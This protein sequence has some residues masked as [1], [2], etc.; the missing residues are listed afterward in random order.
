MISISEFSKTYGD[1]VSQLFKRWVNKYLE[2]QTDGSI[3]NMWLSDPTKKYPLEKWG[4]GSPSP[5]KEKNIPLLQI[6]TMVLP[7]EKI[8]FKTIEEAEVYIEKGIN[9]YEEETEHC[10][11]E[12][13][14]GFIRKT[15]SL[16][17]LVSDEYF[18]NNISKD[19]L[20]LYL[21]FSNHMRILISEIFNKD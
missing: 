1:E 20:P 2:G 13:L 21:G 9:E 17:E 5:E 18:V 7:L 6:D 3:I 11:H 15:Y 19:D 12:V 10:I 14:I 4:T 8:T 16:P